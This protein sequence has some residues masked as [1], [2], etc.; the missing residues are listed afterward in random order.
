VLKLD[1]L[2]VHDN[3]F[4][5]GGY[6]LLAVQLRFQIKR[7]LDIDVSLADIYRW[8]TVEG[9]ALSALQKELEVLGLKETDK[10]LAAMEDLPDDQVETY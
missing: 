5:L 8:P 6:S 1:R 7:V 2:G 10:L 3:F 9:I 4:E